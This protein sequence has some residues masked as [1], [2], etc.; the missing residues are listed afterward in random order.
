MKHLLS[1]FLIILFYTGVAQT[2]NKKRVL[3][4]P[5]SRFEFVSEFDLEVIA[6][7]NEITVAKVFLA[8][9]K[10]LLNSFG[11]YSDENFEFVPVEATKLQPYK[12]L[13]KYKSGK[14][15]GKR[16]NAVDLKGFSEKDFTNLLEQHNCDF[17]IF[18]TWYDIQKEA[19]TRRGGHRKRVKYAGH[20][21]DYD[22]YNLFR[23][24][25]VG[26]A[27][28]KAEAPEPNDLEAS[29]SLLR[30]KELASA[31]YNFIGKV[32]IQLNKPIEVD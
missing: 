16:Y 32:V 8:Y 31:Y 30:T 5:P 17:I 10:A 11:S 14:F 27:R 4:I 20:Y 25:I 19:F 29:F 15:K 7:K 3:V 21:L 28:T 9:E 12:K 18:I 2:S 23:Q 22:I 13:I 6:K 1:I 24:Q 26:T